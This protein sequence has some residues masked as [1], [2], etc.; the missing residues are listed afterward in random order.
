MHKGK[1]GICTPALSL[2]LNEHAG[3][4]FSTAELQEHE[5]SEQTVC[6]LHPH[7]GG[8]RS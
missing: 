7:D 1:A 8:G 5:H 4:T 6:G 3:L 2:L